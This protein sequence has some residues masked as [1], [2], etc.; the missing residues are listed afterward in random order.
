MRRASHLTVRKQQGHLECRR[1]SLIDEEAAEAI[2]MDVTAP[3][4]AA[5]EAA[6]EIHLRNLNCRRLQ[7]DE[8]WTFCRMKQ[9][10]IPR[11]TDRTKIGDQWTFVAIDP[12]TKLIPAYRVGKRTR[13]TAVAF[14]TDLSVHSMVLRV[15]N[16]FI[17]PDSHLLV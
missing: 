1:R 4:R 16:F 3:D 14:M 8:I 7:C 11:F 2:M 12:D 13:E 5:W 6:R 15:S 17:A 9:A 10:R